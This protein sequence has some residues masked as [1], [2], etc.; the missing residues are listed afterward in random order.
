MKRVFAFYLLV[1]AAYAQSN[2]PEPEGYSTSMAPEPSPDAMMSSTGMEASSTGMEASSTGMETSIA[3]S[4]TMMTTGMPMNETTTQ[5]ALQTHVIT[6]A[7]TLTNL[8]VLTTEAALIASV[9]ANIEGSL[10]DG[11]NVAVQ[12]KSMKLT[13]TYDGF[14]EE[15]N[16][17]T[18]DSIIAAM[19][20]MYNDN[21]LDFSHIVVNGFN[22]SS[23]GGRRLSGYSATVITTVPK[24]VNNDVVSKAKT[25]SDANNVSAFKAQLISV[26]TNFSSLSL[27]MQPVQIKLEVTSTVTG[28]IST[29]STSN[30]I[31]AVSG[32]LGG[33]T[34]TATIESSVAATSTN[35]PMEDRAPIAPVMTI[36]AAL[37]AFVMS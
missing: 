5:A 19:L 24:T 13:V 15:I 20:A 37:Y 4:S 2:E 18:A 8:S 14:S 22:H 10:T 3:A 36:W 6:L 31:S 27:T 35:A 16:Q 9:Q 26:N 28:S 32:S 23:V 17:A 1:C 12:I 11:G 30:I 34:V 33:A 7:A 25:F 29:P 21:L